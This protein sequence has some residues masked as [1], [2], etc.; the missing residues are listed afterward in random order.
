[1][2]NCS[3]LGVGVKD[4]IR[5]VCITFSCPFFILEVLPNKTGTPL[6]LVTSDVTA[7]SFRA[8]W[9][10]APGNV[11]RYRVVYAPAQ[12]GEPQEVNAGKTETCKNKIYISSF[13]GTGNTNLWMNKLI[14]IKKQKKKNPVGLVRLLLLL[15]Y[16]NRLYNI[17][18][19]CSIAIKA[20]VSRGTCSWDYVFR[21]LQFLTFYQNC[22]PSVSEHFFRLW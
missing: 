19:T 5:S 22:Q 12:G 15:L 17:I 16:Y 11:H 6:N 1:M 21:P 3:F 18:N 7:H 20:S 8:S 14:M 13:D 2:R 4:G 9:S 10:P